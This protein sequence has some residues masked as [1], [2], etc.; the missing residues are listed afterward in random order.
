MVDSRLINYIKQQLNNGYNITMPERVSS[1]V[2]VMEA[3]LGGY[4]RYKRG[5]KCVFLMSREET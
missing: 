1:F 2:Y 3:L 5:N 4:R